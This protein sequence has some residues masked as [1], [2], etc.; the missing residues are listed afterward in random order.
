VG[1]TAHPLFITV[2]DCNH[3]HKQKKMSY[4]R[5][6]RRKEAASR[7]AASNEKRRF[8]EVSIAEITK[9]DDTVRDYSKRL[10]DTCKWALNLPDYSAQGI[11]KL[12]Q[13]IMIMAALHPDHS[14]FT[15]QF[16]ADVIAYY[17][18]CI[19]KECGTEWIKYEGGPNDDRI[20][21]KVKEG[22]FIF[23]ATK[24]VKFVEHGYK[25]GLYP[26]YLGIKYGDLCYNDN[27][28]WDENGECVVQTPDGDI[29]I[30]NRSLQP[31]QNLEEAATVS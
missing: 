11:K 4:N 15:S 19:N 3:R 12:E 9:D 29:V 20:A 5:R 14:P 25:E 24:L 8:V 27:I 22:S 7:T 26:L 16:M 31:T 1:L 28:I 21:I 13:T 10:A 23:P 6:Q 30:V 18:E 2:G 17:G